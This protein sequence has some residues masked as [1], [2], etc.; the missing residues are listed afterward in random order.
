VWRVDH[1]EK[2]FNLLP[3][4][5]VENANTCTYRAILINLLSA[6]IYINSEIIRQP[7]RGIKVIE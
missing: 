6:Y 3:K 1:N 7:V 5:F 2:Q 4:L